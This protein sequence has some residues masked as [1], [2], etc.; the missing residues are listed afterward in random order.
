[1]AR[2]IFFFLYNSQVQFDA[3]VAEDG[4]TPFLVPVEDS[5]FSDDMDYSTITH[6]GFKH[7]TICQVCMP[8]V[9]LRKGAND[10]DVTH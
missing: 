7:S 6:C 2:G 8:A 4:Y 9:T 1:M 10:K 3:W 5:N